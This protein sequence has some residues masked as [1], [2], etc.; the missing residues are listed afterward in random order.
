M[1]DIDFHYDG[2]VIPFQSQKEEIM[3]NII[4]NF[5]RN[6][7]INISQVF[8]LYDGKIIDEKLPLKSLINRD[9][10]HR[11]KM[12]ILIL[13]NSEKNKNNNST[14]KTNKQYVQ[15]VAK[16]PKLNSKII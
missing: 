1:I 11:K 12:N 5:C 6:E 7:S 13:L 2:S 10:K 16:M 8:F 3:K 9:D 4:N 15:D 14:R